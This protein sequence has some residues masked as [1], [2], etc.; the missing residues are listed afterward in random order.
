MP[1]V[2]VVF[3]KEKNGTV[4]FLLWLDKLSPQ[5]AR[6][7]CLAVVK[8]LSRTGY[9][10]HRPFSDILR[11]GIHELRTRL[12]SINY[13]ILY[14]FHSRDIVILTHGLTKEETVPDREIDRAIHMRDAFKTN[15]E[16]HSYHETEQYYE[17]A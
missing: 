13:R 16:V 4:P 1:E 10:L 15:P 12:G 2:K 3:Y 8:L 17:E 6:G 7:K 9:E 5:K 11:D 14:F